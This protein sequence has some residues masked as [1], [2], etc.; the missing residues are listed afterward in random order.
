[1]EVPDG[2]PKEPSD[3]EL[4][5]DAIKAMGTLTKRFVSRGAEA[6]VKGVDDGLNSIEQALKEHQESGDTPKDPDA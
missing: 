5:L 3:G 4:M 2:T 1:M 6:V